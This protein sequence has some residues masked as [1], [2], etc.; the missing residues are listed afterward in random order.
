LPVDFLLLC[1]LLT[2]AGSFLRALLLA[3]TCCLQLL[4][5]AGQGF[6]GTLQLLLQ[7]LGHLYQPSALDLP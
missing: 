4:P 1:Q 3:P 2:E 5:N 6:L 7:L